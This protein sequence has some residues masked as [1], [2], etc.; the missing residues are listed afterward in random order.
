VK[1]GIVGDHLRGFARAASSAPDRIY[2]D[3]FA[4]CGSGID[5]RTGEIYDGSAALCLNVEPPFTEI[6]LVEEVP[7][8]VAELEQLAAGHR[9]AHVINEDAN[10]AIPR[11]L[12]K[13]N[14]RAPTFAFLD[15]EGTEL[16]WRT[17]ELL[18]RHK[19]GVSP[20]KVELMILFP[21]QMGVLRLLDFKSGVIKPAHARRLDAMLGAETPWREIVR[22]RLQG[23]LEGPRA[24]EYAFLDAYCDG[25]HRRLGYKHV[26]H[27][28]VADGRGRDIYY[29]V[30]ASDHDVGRKLARYEF[31]ASHTEQSALFNVAEYDERLDYDP[32]RERRYRS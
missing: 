30:F 25:L 17:V 23:E 6:F 31:G 28:A 13:M 12:E 9:G 8:R 10:V 18:A 3:G 24:T 29:L 21:L 7:S 19:Q 22:M 11:L 2:L 20:F 27:R 4:G 16:E 1:L 15:P 5:P 26:L 14:P 32:D